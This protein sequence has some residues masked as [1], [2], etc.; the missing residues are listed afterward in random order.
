[1]ASGG[2]LGTCP[3]CQDLIWEDEDWIVTKYYMKHEECDY[4]VMDDLTLKLYRLSRPQQIRMINF[5]DSII[6][7]E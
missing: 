4:K 2:I 3:V 5:L 6:D 1:M 7:E